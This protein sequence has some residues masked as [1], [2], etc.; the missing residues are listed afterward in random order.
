MAALPGILVRNGPLKLAALALAVI[1]WV[2]V[3][4]EET[5]SQLVEVRVEVD[6]PEGLALAKPAPVLR[7]LV[8]GPGRELIKLYSNPLTLHASVPA[9]TQ[10]TR[11][12]LVVAPADV[13]ITR[14]ARVSIQDVEPRTL[15]FELDRLTQRDV[16]VA[17]RGV[18]EAESGF[19]VA[20]PLQIAPAT[21]RVS[22]PRALVSLVDS[23]LTESVDIRGVTGPFERKV[24]L[25]TTGRALLRIAPHEVTISGRTRRS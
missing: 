18:I 7:A 1:L 17:V 6:L 11:W 13:Q 22:G 3:A 25:D 9:S 16:P 4:A 20:R 21:V 23:I 8:T 24:P 14:N 10:P 19:A 2:L 5:T 12:R 15:T